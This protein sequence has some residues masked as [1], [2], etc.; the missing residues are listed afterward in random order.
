LCALRETPFGKIDSED[1]CFLLRHHVGVEIFLDQELD[2]LEQ[3]PL[4]D[5]QYYHG[6]LLIAVLDLDA[7]HLMAQGRAPR[8]ITIAERGLDDPCAQDH[9]GF[10]EQRARIEAG[11]RRLRDAPGNSTI[12]APP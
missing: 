11:L 8:L 6:D 4:A 5:M 2:W 9:P 12:P 1:V 10:E 3:D 7:K